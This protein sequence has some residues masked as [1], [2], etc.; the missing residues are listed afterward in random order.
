MTQARSYKVGVFDTSTYNTTGATCTSASATAPPAILVGQTGSGVA[1]AI[2][3]V[4]VAAIGAASFPSNS[5]YTAV[6]ATFTTSGLTGGNTATPV[7]NSGTALAAQSTWTTAGGNSA[8]A[9]TIG[10]QAMVKI[11]WSQPIPF[12]AG[13]NWSEWFGPGFEKYIPASTNVGL[14]ITESSAGTGTP[15]SGEVEFTE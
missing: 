14:F 5:S 12:S 1:I 2:A 13:G 8:A 9:I 15:F 6:L 4:R 3:C 11:L 7:I 10:T